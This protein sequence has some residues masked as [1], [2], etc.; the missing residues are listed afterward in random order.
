[1]PSHYSMSSYLMLPASS[2]RAMVVLH[3]APLLLRIKAQQHCCM[4]LCLV[5]HTHCMVLLH[6]SSQAMYLNDKLLNEIDQQEAGLTAELSAAAQEADL[7]LLREERAMDR[8][9]REAG[10]HPD[11]QPDSRVATATAAA[12]ATSGS[13]T[14]SVPE[15]T[16]KDI[17]EDVRGA[18][19][20]S[21]DASAGAP[22]AQSNAGLAYSG[23]FSLQPLPQA[24]SGEVTARANAAGTPLSDVQKV[25]PL[26]SDSGV[27]VAK[28]RSEPATSDPVAMQLYLDSPNILPRKEQSQHAQ[29][30][31]HGQPALA[32]NTMQTAPGPIDDG[33]DGNGYLTSNE[34]DY[35]RLTPPDYSQEVQSFHESEKQRSKS[36]AEQL[37]RLQEESRMLQEKSRAL[38]ERAVAIEREAGIHVSAAPQQA[39]QA[40]WRSLP[41]VPVAPEAAPP[42]VSTA[43]SARSTKQLPAA[44]VP[45]PQPPAQAPIQ[46][47]PEET[48]SRATTGKP[49]PLTWELPQRKSA[50]HK[51]TAA[52]AGKQAAPAQ[53]AAPSPPIPG[54]TPPGPIPSQSPEPTV[55]Y[56]HTLAS[57]TLRASEDPPLARQGSS[58]STIEPLL[59]RYENHIHWTHCLFCHV[60]MAM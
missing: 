33:G 3:D 30:A 14:G 25:L 31:Q 60:R 53:A 57:F 42:P 22:P 13:A 55:P 7:S 17:P 27:A 58:T 12:P 4:A 34:L 47:T 35:P 56:S 21:A 26:S 1:M 16:L 49:A 45:P 39:R 6:A 5:Q 10:M 50:A 28:A 41:Q 36:I 8:A 43:R 52:G 19:P 59:P 48:P 51:G 32:E 38:Q 44:A 2:Y 20:A 46:Q 23:S 24:D 9:L 29:H 18:P 54:S 11:D 15:L 40:P 37:A